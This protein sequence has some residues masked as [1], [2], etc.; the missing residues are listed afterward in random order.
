MIYHDIS[1]P[2]PNSTLRL[3]IRWK[4]SKTVKGNT[5]R[6]DKKTMRFREYNANEKKRQVIINNHPNE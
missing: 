3:P 2:Y 6:D 4:N 1:N 5:E